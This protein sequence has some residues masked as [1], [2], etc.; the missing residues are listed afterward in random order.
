MTSWGHTQNSGLGGNGVGL[1]FN[2]EQIK[3][4]HHRGIGVKR[5]GVIVGLK[6]AHEQVG[7]SM[8]GGHR[9]GF[10][11]IQVADVIKKDARIAEIDLIDDEGIDMNHSGEADI[12]GKNA[13]G[14]KCAALLGG[15]A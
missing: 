11:K 4:D 14:G 6:A 15:M 5:H 7:R 3:G 2:V 9:N 8:I 10:G 1:G 13:V 12:A